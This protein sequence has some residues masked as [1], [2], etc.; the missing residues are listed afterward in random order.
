MK[1]NISTQPAAAALF[2]LLTLAAWAQPAAP[3]NMTVSPATKMIVQGGWQDFSI[4]VVRSAGFV[5]PVAL[6]LRGAPT[7]IYGEL[8]TE[9]RAVEQFE[10]DGERGAERAARE[11]SVR[12][13][14][15]GG[16]LG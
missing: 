6:D 15:A 8:F 1:N 16:H 3:F 7:G 9:S 14:R 4:G 10:D 13:S 2:S 5:T 12:G 11:L